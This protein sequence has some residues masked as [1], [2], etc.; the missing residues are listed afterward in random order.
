VLGRV[1]RVILGAKATGYRGYGGPQVAM[2]G[3]LGK[4]HACSI[5][6]IADSLGL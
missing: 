4:I 6:V 2:L 1:L 5:E 3:T